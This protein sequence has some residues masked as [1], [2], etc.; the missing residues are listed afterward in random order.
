MIHWDPTAS[1]ENK[2]L[3]DYLA[4]RVFEHDFEKAWKGLVLF[5]EYESQS[6]L[7]YALFRD[8]VI[9]Y[10]RPFRRSI[11]KYKSYKILS[12]DY[13]PIGMLALHDELMTQ[14]DTIFAHTDIA[15]KSPDL[16]RRRMNNGNGGYTFGMSFK[17]ENLDHFFR[18]EDEIKALIEAVWRK[19]REVIVVRDAELSA[20]LEEEDKKNLPQTPQ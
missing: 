8:V 2:W 16:S 11:G 12:S 20:K 17:H 1:E 14:R 10:S 9:A 3:E 19:I 18:R 5:K 7:A 6:R 15:A 13:I 4:L